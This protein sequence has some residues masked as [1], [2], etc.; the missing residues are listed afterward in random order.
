MS[1]GR[2]D[3]TSAIS[4]R[5][6]GV[7]KFGPTRDRETLAEDGRGSVQHHSGAS[8]ALRF[9]LRASICRSQL[10]NGFE[11]RRLN[12]VQPLFHLAD[13]CRLADP[14]VYYTEAI[15]PA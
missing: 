6:G 2:A 1:G 15:I 14:R 12:Q 11:V 7:G 10:V 8:I 5:F 13:T 9:D 3:A 4:I